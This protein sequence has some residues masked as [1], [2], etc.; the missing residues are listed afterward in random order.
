MSKLNCA[1]SAIFFVILLN[2]F[3]LEAKTQLPTTTVL[4]PPKTRIEAELAY[5]DETRA[6]GLMNRQSMPEDA[7]MLFLFSEMDFQTFWMKNTL[8]PLDLIWLNERK[9]VVYFVTAPPCETD[10]C[11]SYSPLQKAKYV[12]EVNAGFAKKHNITM[13]TRLEFSLP[14]EI[15]R[16]V[17]PRR[18]GFR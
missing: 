14:P 10:P 3:F 18:I 5:T 7:G 2:C 15:E 4:I 13:G 12:L 9:E 16:A 6:T 11:V 1:V 8:I 17:T